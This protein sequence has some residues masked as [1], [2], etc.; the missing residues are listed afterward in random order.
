MKKN[1]SIL[2]AAVIAAC[3]VCAFIF[4]PFMCTDL[5]V[6]I[7]FSDDSAATECSLYYT[8]ADAPNMSEDKQ[9]STDIHDNYADLILSPEYCGKLT[10]LRLDFSPA[11]DLICVSRIELCSGGFVRKSYEPAQF[12]DQSN[13]AAT[14]DLS[15]LQCATNIAYIGTAGNDPY[16]MFQP[17][18][19]QECNDAYSHYTGTKAVLCLFLTGAWILSRKKFF[20]AD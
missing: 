15:S 9:I 14:N 12:F 19:V 20:T 1:P 8:T 17:D 3:A 7:Y 6:K 13:I 10:G 2:I 18:F 11:E 16:L 5:H 4:Y